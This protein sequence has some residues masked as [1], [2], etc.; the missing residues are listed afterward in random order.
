MTSLQFISEIPANM[1]YRADV[2][3]KMKTDDS[4]I[5]DISISSI[6]M[7]PIM[8]KLIIEQGW[9]LDETIF[10]QHRYKQ[11]L[12]LCKIYSNKTIVPSKR[13]DEF[14]HVHILD[15]AKYFKDCD[16][17][18]G[19]YLHHFPYFGIRSNDDYK[20]L[21]NASIESKNL[22]EK[23]FGKSDW[24][25]NTSLCGPSSCGQDGDT[26]GLC[27]KSDDFTSNTIDN[28]RPSLDLVFKK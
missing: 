11:F 22:F 26:G 20:N 15:T 16:T 27:N 13:I 21:Q 10:Y 2:L 23:S 28:Y 14:W 18:F 12:Y 4:Q 9:R 6:D 7:E 24:Y 5:P 17:I 3:L 19:K 1:C 25:F 8:V